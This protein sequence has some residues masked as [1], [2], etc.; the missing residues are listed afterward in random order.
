MKT[1]WQEQ[2]VIV[3]GAARQG[4]AAARFLAEKGAKVTLSD[5]R[6]LDQL[7]DEV[8]LLND[9]SVEFAF[10]DHPEELLDD[11]SMIC[12]SGGVPL[13]IP[14]V[15]KAI[16]HGKQLTNDAQI[17]ME[18]VPCKVIGITGSAGKTTT[19]TLLG[20][21]A[22][23]SVE[24]DG[25][26][27]P[28]K[29]WVG[30]NIGNPLISDVKDM[31]K[32]DVV[33]MELSSFQLDLMTKVPQVSAVLN[34][35]P[36]HLDRHGSMKSYTYA[37]AAMLFYQN[38]DDVAVL[39]REDAGSWA[40]LPAVAGSLAS[41][42]KDKLE[43]NAF[44]SWLEDDKIFVRDED[45]VHEVLHVDEISLRGEHNL[46]NVLA[47]VAIATVAGFSVKA[48]KQGVQGFSG[49]VHR[50][51]LVREWGGAKWINDSIATA[52]ER[53]MAAVNTFDEPIVLILGGRDKKLP[54]DVLVELIREKVDHVVLFGEMGS[55]V[56]EAIGELVEGERPYSVDL[57]VDLESAVTKT[58][59]VI[60]EGDVVLLS[61]GGTSYDA[62]LDFE[63]RGNHFRSLVEQL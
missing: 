27:A 43:E 16:T 30:G 15:Q 58:S 59:E 3:L 13:T 36:N 25:E 21:I 14:F 56:A 41:F 1:N 61:P 29:A 39:G 6:P 53:S 63:E 8:K 5:V 45:G 49:V 10:G 40:L 54:W 51:E 62:Y 60:E 26:K 4:L 12:V 55:M 46:M 37:K 20:R 44:G 19:T 48:I 42:G 38:E 52:P 23:A 50:Q 28:R 17:F 24:N 18:E 9:T 35:T 22:E 2:N 33:V 34:I 57:T 7:Q 32:E 11:A 31:Q 47:A